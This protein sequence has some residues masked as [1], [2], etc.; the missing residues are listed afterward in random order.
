MAFLRE[1]LGRPENERPFLLLVVGF[2]AAGAQVPRI[3]RKELEEI[4]V[5]LDPEDPQATS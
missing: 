5:F 3:R 1:I 4:A 2:P